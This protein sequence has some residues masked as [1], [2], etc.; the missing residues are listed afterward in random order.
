MELCGWGLVRKL[1]VSSH[2]DLHVS[3]CDVEKINGIYLVSFGGSILAYIILILTT[4]ISQLF[5]V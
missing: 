5:L 1:C 4:A 3:S 2:E